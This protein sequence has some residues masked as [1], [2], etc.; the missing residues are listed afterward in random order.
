MGERSSDARFRTCSCSSS[1]A[2]AVSFSFGFFLLRRRRHRSSRC[3]DG[4]REKTRA[5]AY[6]SLAADDVRARALLPTHGACVINCVGGNEQRARASSCEQICRRGVWD[7]GR[8]EEASPADGNTGKGKL[9]A[10]NEL[11]DLFFN[12]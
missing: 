6:R 10:R 12:I 2:K 11:F 8:K 4:N 1:S 9:E 7:L 5:S 3:Q